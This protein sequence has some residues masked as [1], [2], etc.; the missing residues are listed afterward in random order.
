MDEEKGDQHV[1]ILTFLPLPGYDLLHLH[2]IF[3]NFYRSCLVAEYLVSMWTMPQCDLV[4]I[5][6]SVK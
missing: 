5:N 3:K 6:H 1:S 2:T 4:S